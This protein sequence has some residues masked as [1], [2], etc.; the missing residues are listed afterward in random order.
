MESSEL[1]QGQ[2]HT[3]EHSSG[4]AQRCS[5]QE[6]KAAVPR[7]NRA[8]LGGCQ[9]AAAVRQAAQH[10]N[11]VPDLTAEA[12]FWPIFTTVCLPWNS[13][14]KPLLDASRTEM[15]EEAISGRTN[16][17]V[18]VRGVV[19]LALPSRCAAAPNSVT[20]SP[21]TQL[22]PTLADSG[23]FSEKKFY[24]SYPSLTFFNWNVGSTVCATCIL[25]QAHIC[26]TLRTPPSR[27]LCCTPHCV[28][29]VSILLYALQGH[30]R[31]L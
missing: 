27:G 22:P 5:T 29:T 11:L 2:G 8:S 21:L 31:C 23:D 18:S 24:V 12:T 26:V 25:K 28:G 1:A 10:I 20:Q 30:D 6:G 14:W 13:V 16:M 19:P 4:L 15:R 17:R 3:C 9:G 7:V